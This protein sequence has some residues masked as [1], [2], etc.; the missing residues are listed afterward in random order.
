MNWG[1]G[2]YNNNDAGNNDANKL[3]MRIQ[4]SNFSG[5]P[6]LKEMLGKCY[7]MTDDK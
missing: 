7:S 1:G 2:G 6:H 4:P 3:N 5:P